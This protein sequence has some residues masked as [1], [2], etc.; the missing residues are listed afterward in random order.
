[1]EISVQGTHEVWVRPEVGRLSVSARAEASSK[2]EVV[3]KVTA[4]VT[5]VQAELKRLAGLPSAPVRDVIVRPITTSSWRPVE[6]GRIQPSI[7]TADA[8]LRA[9]FVDFGALADFGATFGA[10]EG[11]NLDGVEWRLTEETRRA[12]EAE[13]LTSAVG[14]ARERA[15][16]MAGAAGAGEVRFVQLS[17]PGLMSDRPEP[18]PRMYAMADAVR[19]AAGKELQGLEIAPEDLLVSVV[20]HARFE[21]VD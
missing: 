14:A 3:D 6:K 19:G 13:C 7:F 5:G 9:D 11:L 21:T 18:S 1:M 8:G 17:D 20:V 12:T 15:Q 4:V 16:V 2:S 10:V